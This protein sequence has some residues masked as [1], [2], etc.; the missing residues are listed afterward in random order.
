MFSFQQLTTLLILLNQDSFAAKIKLHTQNHGRVY[1]R[2]MHGCGKWVY[3]AK[4]CTQLADSLNRFAEVETTEHE[5]AWSLMC[6]LDLDQ[7]S[8]YSQIFCSSWSAP[9]KDAA[10]ILSIRIQLSNHS[11]ASDFVMILNWIISRIDLRSVS[12]GNREIIL[13]WR[14]MIISWLIF[15]NKR[16]SRSSRQF[17]NLIWHTGWVSDLRGHTLSGPYKIL[18]FL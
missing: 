2:G 14:N 7:Y 17:E 16:I 3:S 10:P 8:W 1:N 11:I 5:N 12:T 6:A 18:N 9:I 15:R 4:V 13:F